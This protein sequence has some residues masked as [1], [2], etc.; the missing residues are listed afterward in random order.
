M[1]DD[2]AIVPVHKDVAL[3]E[4][5]ALLDVSLSALIQSLETG[6]ILSTGTGDE[7]RIGLHDL[8]AYKEQR[9]AD[10]KRDLATALAVVQEAGAYD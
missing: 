6:A 1:A 8:V 9:S 2:V 7:R 3:V 5:A 4:A 10:S